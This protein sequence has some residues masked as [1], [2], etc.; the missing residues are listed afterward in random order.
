VE[1]LGYG[2]EEAAGRCGWGRTTMCDLIRRGEVESIK[3]GR[4]RI[5]PHDAL[6]AF[7]DRMR[8]QQS[9]GDAS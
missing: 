4:R 6:V 2:I 8:A 7:L 1:K 9:G 5:I 3:V